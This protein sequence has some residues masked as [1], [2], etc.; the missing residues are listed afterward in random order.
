MNYSLNPYSQNLT[1]LQAGHLLRRATMGP[2]KAE[3]NSFTG[4]SATNA[5][6]TLINNITT[7]PHPVD[8]RYDT[9]TVGQVYYNLPYNSPRNPDFRDFHKNW[10]L[11]IM[12]S[13]SA[14][15]SLADKL[16]LFWQNHF[17]TTRDVVDEH[18]AIYQY[19][20]LIRS[21]ILGNLKT[22][23]KSMT[24]NTAMLKYLNGNENIKGTPNENY[25]RELMELFV[26]GAKDFA[27][28]N[29]YTEDDVKAAARVLT[30]WQNQN[31]YVVNSLYAS[32]SSY[33]TLNRHDTN[34]KQFSSYYPNSTNTGA[35]IINTPT[36]TPPNYP[37]VG[38]Y[39]LD[40]LLDMLFRHPETPKFIC[41]KLYRFFV[42]PNVTPDI[43]T[44]VIAPLANLFKSIDPNTGKAFEIKPVITTLLA[45]EHFF[46]EEN[47]GSMIKSPLEFLVGYF[48][49]FGFDVPA[50]IPS[51]LQNTIRNHL[52]YSE[53]LMKG[54]GPIDAG[55]ISM[56][57]DLL[58]QQTVFGY[59]A[60]YQPGYTR[61]WINT[62]QI[63]LRNGFIDSIFNGRY[64]V[65]GITPQVYL[66]MDTVAMAD[67]PTTTTPYYNATDCVAILDLFLKHLFATEISQNQK[68]FLIDTI[69]MQGIP[70]TSWVIEWINFKAATLGTPNYTTRR[71]AVKSRL[72]NLLKF[73]VKMA[74]YHIC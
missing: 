19:F 29:N 62:T 36:T 33:F 30:G 24:L 47:I 63:G 48:R 59:D 53:F 1:A 39:E 37:N 5:I 68:T 14:A 28:N 18:R 65:S 13:Q 66:I 72:D 57:M 16:T 38:E 8:L 71:N 49:Y 26:V 54:F 35:T 42:N 3:V 52:A 23:A 51:N 9:A 69:M 25:A 58:D 46:D 45:S 67:Q 12:C 10:W 55:T 34:P 41:R 70:R 60:Y 2:T 31:M 27:G 32:V 74:E 17:V 7:P 43:E 56:Q 20:T 22:F 11:N 4:L 44:N 50:I 64:L 61:N 73:M 40:E 6:Q 15:P 21:S